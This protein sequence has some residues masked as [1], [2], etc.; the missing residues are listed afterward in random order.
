MESNNFFCYVK[1]P[2]FI[3]KSTFYQQPQKRGQCFDNSD[4]MI[5]SASLWLDEAKGNIMDVKD[6][7][8]YPSR[9][10]MGRGS[11]L[12]MENVTEAIWQEQWA[13]NAKKRRKVR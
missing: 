9:L 13:Q 1:C 7:H 10:R 5:Q 12:V 8:G 11:E 2:I 6:K 4:C 3:C